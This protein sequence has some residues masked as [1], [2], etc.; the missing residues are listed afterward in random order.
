MVLESLFTVCGKTILKIEDSTFLP[1]DALKKRGTA[2]R[3]EKNP[4]MMYR[5]LC[6]TCEG[7]LSAYMNDIT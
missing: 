5:M 2:V 1:K 7:P 4:Y 6:E 3:R